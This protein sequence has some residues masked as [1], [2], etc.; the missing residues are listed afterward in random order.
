MFGEQQQTFGLDLQ[1]IDLI[2]LWF[3]GISSFL[4]PNIFLHLK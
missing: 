2:L 4:P 3:V 1:L